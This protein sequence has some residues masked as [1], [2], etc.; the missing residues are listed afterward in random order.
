MNPMKA[1]VKMLTV[2]DLGS[3]MD[4]ML[5]GAER[6]LL[7]ATGGM[8][9]LSKASDGLKAV[10]KSVDRDLDSGAI[11]GD[12]TA[13]EAATYVKGVLSRAHQ[14]L[15]DLALS[16]QTTKLSASGQVSGIKKCV[17]LAKKTYDVEKLK[18]E[19]AVARLEEA[20]A[21]AVESGEDPVKVVARPRSNAAQK[22]LQARKAKA[23]KGKAL[24]KTQK[25]KKS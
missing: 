3:E 16:A 20:R 6:S 23:R 22:D 24:K 12:W 8:E 2:Q 11:K 14:S 19:A 18:L 10:S 13:M 1:Q 5:E 17:D 21:K 15:A 25:A 9:W 7:T 4:D